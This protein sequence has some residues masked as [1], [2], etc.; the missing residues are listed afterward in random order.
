MVTWL[1]SNASLAFLLVHVIISDTSLPHRITTPLLSLFEQYKH[2][3]LL[4]GLKVESSKDRIKTKAQGRE[5]IHAKTKTTTSRKVWGVIIPPVTMA[6]A[7]RAR[8]SS[9]VL[10]IILCGACFQPSFRSS[11]S[12]SSISYITNFNHDFYILWWYPIMLWSVRISVWF[13]WTGL[14]VSDVRISCMI[15][16]SN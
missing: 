13:I 14:L 3:S 4:V 15:L 11:S 2:F 9:I 16:G 10:G 8:A 7:C 5:K 1:A 12:R 6:G